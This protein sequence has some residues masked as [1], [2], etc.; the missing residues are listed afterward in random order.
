MLSGRLLQP[1]MVNGSLAVTVQ[2]DVLQIETICE[3]TSVSGH[4]DVDGTVELDV[5]KL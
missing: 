1:A 3:R 5:E 4:A 2:G